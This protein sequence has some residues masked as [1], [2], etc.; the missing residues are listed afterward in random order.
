VIVQE[1]MRGKGIGSALMKAVA[2]H[3]DVAHTYCIL[4][5]RPN[6]WL[7]YFRAADFHVFDR[8]SGLMQR[9]PR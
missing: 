2:E 3:P 5:A 8:K 7:F 1:D 4:R 9:M 6:A